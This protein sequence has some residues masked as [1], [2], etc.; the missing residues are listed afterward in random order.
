MIENS[1]SSRYTEGGAKL[2]LKV[3]Q[4][5]MDDLVGEEQGEASDSLRTV[6]TKH[7]EDQYEYERNMT[8]MRSLRDTLSKV[9]VADWPKDIEGE[10]EKLKEEE[11]NN[12]AV[13]VNN[14][15]WIKEMNKI[16]EGNESAE[17]M[18]EGDDD[19]E[20]TQVEV[21]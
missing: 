4:R 17:E 16:L 18:P 5:I 1:N 9:S 11:R 20:M 14:H 7:V 10:F 8:A 21:H 12:N 6:M 3:C 15:P 13:D 19:L 2:T